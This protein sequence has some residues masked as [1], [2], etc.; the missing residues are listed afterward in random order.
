MTNHRYGVVLFCACACVS[1][2]MALP[3]KGAAVQ[4]NTVARPKICLTPGSMPEPAPVPAVDAT[5]VPAP[6]RAHPDTLV[7]PPAN[8]PRPVPA[9]GR[10]VRE[11][12][13]STTDVQERRGDLLPPFSATLSGRNEVRIRNPNDFAVA[14][15][16]RSGRRGLDSKVPANGVMSMYVP[17]GAYEIY[18]VYSNR[19]D[20]LFQGDKFTLSGNGIEISIVKV[21][22]GNYQIRQV[23]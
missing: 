19:P 21:V 10:R 14:V 23:K 3:A 22:N 16:V 11:A 2:A 15:G 1:M 20:A 12:P 7:P 8:N 17:D 5:R 4:S 9:R 6:E 13:A 18:F